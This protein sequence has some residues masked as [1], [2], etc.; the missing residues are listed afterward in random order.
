MFHVV[1]PASVT[2]LESRCLFASLPFI[3]PRKINLEGYLKGKHRHRR[4]PRYS[5]L[6]NNSCQK[7]L[8]IVFIKQELKV[9]DFNKFI[10]KIIFMDCL[11]ISFHNIYYIL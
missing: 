2:R 8:C 6:I 5:K 10:R 1:T 9:L 3:V 4:V 11:N 7:F